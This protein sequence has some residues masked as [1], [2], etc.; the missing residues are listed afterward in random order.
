[1]KEIEKNKIL[2]RRAALS[3]H[4]HFGNSLWTGDCF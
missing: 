2:G 1:M 3:A 4:I